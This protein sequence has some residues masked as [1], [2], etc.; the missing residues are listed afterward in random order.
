ML[1]IVF[2]ALIGAFILILL[3]CLSIAS[4]S[5]SNMMAAFEKINKKMSGSFTTASNFAA[6][7]SMNYLDG[8]VRVSNR[9]GFLTD[10][11]QPARKIVFLSEE[12]FNNSSVAALAIAA[13]ELGHALQD[14]ENP[15]I[16]K[17]RDRLGILAKLVGFF[18]APLFVGGIVTYFLYPENLMYSLLLVGAGLA[19]FLLA[20]FVKLLTINIEKDASKRALVFLRELNMLDEDE[21]K[22]ADKLLKAAL[23]TYIGDFLRAILSWTMLTRKTKLF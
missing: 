17:R 19:I 13:H 20:L 10:A 16:L 14:K 11:Y 23:L 5:G 6:M 9:K 2:Y 15:E 4:Y 22:E 8:K 12:I 3:I 7:V 1:N 21:I 18:M